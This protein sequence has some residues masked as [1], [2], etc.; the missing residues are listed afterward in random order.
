MGRNR[1]KD[2][3]FHGI[4]DGLLVHI[5]EVENGLK[6]NC[7]CPCCNEPLIAKTKSVKA[8]RIKSFAHTANTS[9]CAYGLQ[10]AIHLRAKTIIEQAGTISLPANIA[11]IKN[12]CEQSREYIEYELLTHPQTLL[13]VKEVILEQKIDDFIPDVILVFEDGRKLLVEI[14]VTHF[15][16]DEKLKKSKLQM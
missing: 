13:N 16:D 7:T 2:T 8:E 11:I 10:T 1:S 4:R 5:S 9:N 12:Y 15:V 14:A 3:L 6:C